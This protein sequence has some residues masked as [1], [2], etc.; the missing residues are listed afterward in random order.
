MQSTTLIFL[1]HAETDKDPKA[2]A[3]V[4]GLSQSGVKQAQALVDINLMHQVDVVYVSEHRKTTLTVEPLAMKLGKDPI[5]W[6]EFNEVKQGDAFLSPE[7][8]AAEKVRQLHDL[9]YQA[10]GGGESGN[11]ALARFHDGVNRVLDLHTGEVVLI[12]TH[13][14]V[15]NL[16]FAD[17]LDSFDE[18]PE[19]WKCTGFAAY[20]VVQNGRVIKD[21]VS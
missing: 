12:V 4:W 11:Q 14:T 15:L 21:I 3:A 17:L 8:F 20:G 6:S 9:E 2:N 13:G 10:F 1:R 7:E 5:V 16:Y 19:R 18:L